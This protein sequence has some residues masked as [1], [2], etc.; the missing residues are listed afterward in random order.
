MDIRILEM[1]T[2][3]IL[4]LINK[5]SRPIKKILKKIRRQS[6]PNGQNASRKYSV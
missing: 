1:K 2:Q 4:K 3:R 5:A 6:L